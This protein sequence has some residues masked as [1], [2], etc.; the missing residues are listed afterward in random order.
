MIV[1][2]LRCEAA[3]HVFEGWFGSTED[4]ESQRERGLVQCPLCGASDVEKAVMA[5]RVRSAG[6][7]ARS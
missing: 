4:Y 7:A 3:S 6:R 5:P 1:F 2:D